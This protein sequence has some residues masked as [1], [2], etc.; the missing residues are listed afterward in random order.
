LVYGSS[1]TRYTGTKEEPDPVI[2]DEAKVIYDTKKGKWKGYSESANYNPL[3][4]NPAQIFAGYSDAQGNQVSWGYLD[5]ECDGFAEVVLKGH[6]SSLSAKAHISAGPPAFA[7]DSLPIR[8]V[9][10]ELEQILLG[11]EVE[12]DVPIDEAEEM[13]RRSLE[14]IRL[15]NTAVMNG[16]PINGRL[17]VVST[18]VR[19]N[20]NDFSRYYGPMMATSLVDNTALRAL[21]ERVFNGL[22]TG[23]AAWFGD[24]LR[25]PEDIGDLSDEGLRQMPGLMRG[26][27]GRMLTLTRRNI[28][29]VIAAAAN[30]MFAKPEGEIDNSKKAGPL[31][32]DDLTAQLHYRGEGN[33]YS[34]L[35]RTAI[36]N[37]F[38]GLEFDFRN[39]WRR[40]FAGIVLIENNN[41]VIDADPEYQHLVHTRLVAID[42]KPTAVPTTGPTF[43][44]GS[45]VALPTPDNP[46]AVSFMEWSNNMVYVLQ[47]Q[48]QM[49]ELVFTK[50]ASPTQV[51]PSK[52]DIDN[53][54]SNKQLYQKHSLRVNKMFEPGTATPSSEVV[55]PG[56]LTQGLCAPWQNDYR[57]CA[58][59]YWAATRPD[60]VNVVNGEDGLSQGD[61]WLSKHRTGEYVPDNRTD[62]R[63]VS[64]DDLFENWQGELNFLIRGNDALEGG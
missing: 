5:D 32:V 56:E 54:Y 45:S 50:E 1:L 19:Q 11:P 6:G 8:V 34:V 26:A 36:S 39:F 3:Y 16:N 46:N 7:P 23:A 25:R 4:T 28:N 38:P 20:T 24:A 14:T 58:C 22:A 15:M 55:R 49:V 59:Y 41:Y 53:G 63:L 51:V 37:C 12:G 44:N 13:V 61:N 33:P 42:G 60:Y 40:A 47:K 17:N 29:L 31:L 21:H 9:S 43:P 30:A 27:D 48:G 64:Y 52:P 35:P 2:T 57:E 10:D 62:S 18:M